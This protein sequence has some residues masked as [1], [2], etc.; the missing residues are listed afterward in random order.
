[1]KDVFSLQI[2]IMNLH[3]VDCLNGILNRFKVAYPNNKAVVFFDSVDKLKRVSR[4]IVGSLMIRGG[5][6]ADE[7]NRIVD[8]YVTKTEYPIL[9]GT[10]LTSNGIDM[11]S[12]SL[13][14]F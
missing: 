13:I 6:N 7:K 1:M 5:L 11:K 8:D 3:T 9:C 12:I 4:D 14:V 2:S 10:K